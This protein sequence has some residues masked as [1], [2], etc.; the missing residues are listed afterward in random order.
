MLCR[1]FANVE[2]PLADCDFSSRRGVDWW[3]CRLGF[4]AI[5]ATEARELW[6]RASIRTR[7]CRRARSR[8]GL[9][10]CVAIFLGVVYSGKEV[11]ESCGAVGNGKFLEGRI[12]GVMDEAQKKK[13]CHPCR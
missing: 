8:H 3:K 11:L 9:Q 2:G 1:T 5:S 4:L 7:S 6:E 13:G 10:S 12:I